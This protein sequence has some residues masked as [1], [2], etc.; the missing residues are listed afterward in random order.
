M[1]D[2]VAGL[3]DGYAELVKHIP[4][5]IETLL[6]LGCGTGL[7]LEE[8]FKVFPSVRVTGIDL[9]QIM[10]NT[11]SDKYSGKNIKLICTSYL[12]HDFGIEQYDCVI[13]FETLHHLTHVQKT[14]LYRYVVKALKPGGRYVEGD[15]MVETQEQE[16]ELFAQKAAC[17]A[18]QNI[19][20]SDLYHFDTPCTV[21]NQIKMLLSAGFATVKKVWRSGNTTIIVGQK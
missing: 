9:S 20:D 10:L 21:D 6:D 5:G 13:S 12:N 3:I 8:I 1:R 16:D 14:E 2:N 15:Y 18:A 19:K 11:L 17:Y 4:N 7:E